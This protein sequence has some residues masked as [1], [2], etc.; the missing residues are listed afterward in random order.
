MPDISLSFRALLFADD[1]DDTPC[2]AARA[3]CRRYCHAAAADAAAAT[4]PLRC[5]AA[6]DI[7]YASVM[8]MLMPRH[9]AVVNKR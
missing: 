1:A 2:H 7:Y 8:M 4:M 6:I 3:C 5:H 9:E